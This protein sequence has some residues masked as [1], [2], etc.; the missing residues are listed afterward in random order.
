AADVPASVSIA[1]VRSSGWARG[2]SN[3]TSGRYTRTGASDAPSAAR[4]TDAPSVAGASDS[5]AP[6]AA[7]CTHVGTS[8]TFAR[9]VVGATA[10]NAPTFGA[11]TSTAIAIDRTMRRCTRHATTSTA[12]KH[13][14]QTPP[15]NTARW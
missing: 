7:R 2:P 5:D 4:C 3:I 1:V 12:A 9:E 11:T 10:G 15:A 8:S 6:S 13:A 14:M